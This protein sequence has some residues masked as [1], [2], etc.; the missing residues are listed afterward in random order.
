MVVR[1]S[2]ARGDKAAVVYERGY[3]K[4][5]QSFAMG[6][7]IGQYSLAAGEYTAALRQTAVSPI[8]F[9]NWRALLYPGWSLGKQLAVTAA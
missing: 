7:E 6:D 1:L 5:V 3:Q 8:T 4:N 2:T 9:T